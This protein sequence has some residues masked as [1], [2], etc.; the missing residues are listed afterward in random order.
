MSV[1][2][3]QLRPISTSHY[4]TSGDVT[5]HDGAAIAPGVLLQADPGSRVIIKTGA[6]IGIGSVLH[7]SQ[8][9]VEV[10]EGANIGA[11]VL[12]I[13]NVSI[14]SNACIGAATTICNWSI[15]SGQMVPSGSLMGDTSRQA[16]QPLQVTETVPLSSP[17]L[18]SESPQN[19][20]A[21]PEASSAELA[22]PAESSGVNV[23][24]QVYVNQ[25]LVK[26]FPN[27]HRANQPPPGSSKLSASDDPWED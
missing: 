20:Q 14:G 10:G 3:L 17:E 24:G 15:E 25:L 22:A 4:Y 21:S 1:P 9:A 26:M 19:G 7:A 5:I 16:E 23:Y 6:C 27:S 11:E 13:G 2:P 8:G 12:L 18:P